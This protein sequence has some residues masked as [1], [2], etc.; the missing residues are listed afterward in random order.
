MSPAPAKAIP[1]IFITCLLE[2]FTGDRTCT[3]CERDF[4]GEAIPKLD[5]TYDESNTC[6]V[7]GYKV[8]GLYVNGNLE[9]TWEQ[10]KANSYIT[11]NDK[12]E[13]TAV[14]PSLYGTMVVEEGVS[15]HYEVFNKCALNEIYLPP[16]VTYFRGGLFRDSTAL[17]A[18]YTIAPVSEIRARAFQGC[19]SLKTVVLHEGTKEIGFDAFRDCVS[20]EEIHLPDSITKIED[21]VFNNCTALKRINMPANLKRIEDHVFS[22]CTSITEI[23]LPEG[24]EYIGSRTFSNSGVRELVVPSSVTRIE[25]M[26]D[27]NLVYLDLSKTQITSLIHY[28][29]EN[30]PYLETI[31]LPSGLISFFDDTFWNCPCLNTKALI[32]RSFQS[33]YLVVQYKD[34]MI[35]KYKRVEIYGMAGT[36][37]LLRRIAALHH[38]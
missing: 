1:A 2:G 36:L 35:S 23:I 33:A 3:V 29:F 19:S 30:S 38:I 7:C 32:I 8:A 20:L 31:A 12:N 14:A 9:F 18:V 27:T 26:S 13:L 34:M 5:H 15:I 28:A 11:L 6:T 21:D 22:D 17:E 25:N 24:L 10:M 16:S 4:D 37:P